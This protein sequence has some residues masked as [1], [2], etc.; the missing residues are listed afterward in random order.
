M[1]T[2]ETDQQRV[3]LLR[4]IEAL[5]DAPAAQ[6]QQGYDAALARLYCL[7]EALADEH[8]WD[9]VAAEAEASE[10][11]T[12]GHRRWGL[13][14]DWDTAALAQEAATSQARMAAWEQRAAADTTPLPVVLPDA[15]DCSG[16]G[17]VGIVPDGYEGGAIPDAAQ[18]ALANTLIR[19]VV[20]AVASDVEQRLRGE[21]SAWLQ[22]NELEL[23]GWDA[24]GWL[25][26]VRGD[27]AGTVAEMVGPHRFTPATPARPARSWRIS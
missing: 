8:R 21:I 18:T 17:G 6:R 4:A 26:A 16:D 24:P 2:T 19:E 11:V 10:P 13:N 23:P 5:R 1:K 15:D 7:L 25:G 20:D 27:L 9:V 22:S 12:L 14:R 3:A